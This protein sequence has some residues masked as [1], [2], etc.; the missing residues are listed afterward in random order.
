MR[1][2]GGCAGC[3]SFSRL[4]SRCKGGVSEEKMPK[5]G[6]KCRLYRLPS[7][8]PVTKRR[9]DGSKLSDWL[10][11][12]FDDGRLTGDSHGRRVTWS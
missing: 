12:D 1:E 9:S 8:F 3:V 5:T 7:I 4:D 11:D 6:D 10:P 2:K